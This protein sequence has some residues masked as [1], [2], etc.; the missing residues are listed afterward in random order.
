MSQTKIAICQISITLV[1]NPTRIYNVDQHIKIV[2]SCLKFAIEQKVN[3]IIFPEYSFLPE[4]VDTYKSYSDNIIIIGGSYHS[5]DNY[6][7]T[8]VAHHGKLYTYNKNYLSP[9]EI[10]ISPSHCLKSGEENPFYFEG[11]NEQ[12]ISVL[13]CLDYFKSVRNVAMKSLPN[14]KMIDIVFSPTCNPNPPK[15]IKEGDSTH[16][17]RDTFYSVLCNVAKLLKVNSD[18]KVME[19]Q[20]FGK[21]CVMGMY[22][23]LIRDQLVSSGLCDS[24]YENMIFQLPDGDKIGIISLKVPYY[25]HR[26]GSIEYIDNP[27][28]ISIYDIDKVG[29]MTKYEF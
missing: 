19:E 29:N 20:E 13:T 4:L 2:E 18:G 26:R 24:S 21:S 8:V 1:S 12:S 5:E 3:Y 23:K 22:E 17:H 14:E 27:K 15:L 25:R 6:N 9:Y 11:E 7:R 10:N 16:N 28:E